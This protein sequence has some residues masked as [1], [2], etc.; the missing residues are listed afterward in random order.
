MLPGAPLKI[1]NGILESPWDNLYFFIPHLGNWV[2]G[3]N[4][5]DF[6]KS[7]SKLTFKLCKI[8]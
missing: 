5:G 8:L 4:A 3:G 6:P 1:L 7:K 2:D